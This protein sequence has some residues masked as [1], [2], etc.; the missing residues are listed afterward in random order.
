MTSLSGNSERLIADFFR[1]WLGDPSFE[2]P[3][4]RFSTGRIARF[5]VTVLRIQGITIGPLVLIAP[6]LLKRLD[7]RSKLP[8]GLVVHEIAHVVQYR[9]HGFIGFLWKYF[10]DYARNL[11]S[12]GSF[13]SNAR[14]A[15][16]LA[17]PFEI[18]ARQA[19]LDFE[20]WMVSKSTAREFRTEPFSDQVP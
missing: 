4:I 2:L 7:G 15:A 17:I 1:E 12:A 20:R 16:Y 19:A 13:D 6:A 9:Q 11:R 5:V 18:E 14:H 10:R 3:N 8:R